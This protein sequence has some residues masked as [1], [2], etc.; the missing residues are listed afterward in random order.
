MKYFSLRFLSIYMYGLILLFS[1]FFD[2]SIYALEVKNFKLV[3]ATVDIGIAD[4]LAHRK[5]NLS[6]EDIE[7][8]GI[9]ITNE[10]HKKGYTTSYVERL[11]LRENGVLDIHIKESRILGIR[12]SGLGD[13]EAKDIQMIIVPVKGEVYNRYILDERLEGVKSK[14]NFD[15]ILH[16]KGTS[17]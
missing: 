3:G 5:G 2:R 7:S 1:S 17:W 8:I 12:I 14:Y 4:I 9:M 13:R 15:T 10:Y 16:C 11:I 6:R